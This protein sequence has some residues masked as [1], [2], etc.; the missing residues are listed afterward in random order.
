VERE[1]IEA[2]RRKKRPDSKEMQTSWGPGN[3]MMG[4]LLRRPYQT[5]CNAV[6]IQ[7]A[8]ELYGA[9]GQALGVYTMH[10]FGE[11]EAIAE[12]VIQLFNRGQGK[13]TQTLGKLE[14]T[15]FDAARQYIGMEVL[16]L[17]W[18]KLVEM[19]TP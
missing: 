2:E 16:N 12:V 18:N 8:K 19:V 7:R 13:D 5:G 17:D 3:L 15:R 4:S 9:N 14:R 11:T 1:R 10:G 6:Y